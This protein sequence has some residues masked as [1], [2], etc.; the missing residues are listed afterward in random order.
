MRD[1]VLTADQHATLR[2][3]LEDLL[4]F[5]A[6]FELVDQPTLPTREEAHVLVMAAADA[7][8]VLDEAIAVSAV[9][10]VRH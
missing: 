6:Y 3:A 10:D 2:A 5:V 1:V 7:L 4:D 9:G 8:D